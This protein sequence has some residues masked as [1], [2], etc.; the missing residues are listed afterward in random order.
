[1][2]ETINKLMTA[3]T[4]YDRALIGYNCAP[5]GNSLIDGAIEMDLTQAKAEYKRQLIEAIHA[6]AIELA[7]IS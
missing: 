4:N 6:L 1:M 3:K 7:E 5:H 2:D